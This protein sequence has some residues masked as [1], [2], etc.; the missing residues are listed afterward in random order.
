MTRAKFTAILI[1]VLF[2]YIAL[3]GACITAKFI[4]E[5]KYYDLVKDISTFAAA[6]P[7]SVLAG[8]YQL[9]TSFL[10]QLRE[11]WKTSLDSVQD[12]IQ[13]TFVESPT[14]Q[15]FS[16][17]MKK[18]S[19]AIDDFRSLYTNL[20]EDA[21]SEGYFPFEGLKS[22]PTTLS[23]YYLGKDYTDKA[24]SETRS[25]ISQTWKRLRKAILSEFDRPSPSKHDTPYIE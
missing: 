25:E 10:Q 1:T 3:I 24:Q 17:V 12:A 9:R 7:V 23:S 15:E 13:F 18:L 16:T 22:I 20:N 8:A 4:G 11:A 19:V 14:P 21:Q 6:L 2:A 5:G